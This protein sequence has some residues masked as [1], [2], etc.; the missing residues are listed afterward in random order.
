MKRGVLFLLWVFILLFSLATFYVSYTA[1]IHQKERQV[2]E[3][4]STFLHDYVEKGIVSLPYPEVMVLKVKKEGRIFATSNFNNPIS[5][6]NFVYSV[7]G[8]DDKS[9]EVYLRKSSLDE[10]VL[11]LF[12]NP[13]L[14]AANLFLFVIY[15]SFFYFM[16]KELE[17]KVPEKVEQELGEKP[18][19]STELIN[20]VKALKVLLHTE[21]ILGKEA[22]EKAKKL[23][24]EILRK[25]ENK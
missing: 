2:V 11:F 24:D 4:V 3:N 20:Q 10:F 15:L 19:L 13:V 17:A 23:V 6:E 14:L 18:T 21:R 7:K 9:V 25:L 16:V 8:K 12:A 5:T 1:Y 22:S